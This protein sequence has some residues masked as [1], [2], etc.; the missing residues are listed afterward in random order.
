MDEQNL[1]EH[2]SNEQR[3]ERQWNMF[4]HLSLL[5]GFVI[6]FAGLVVP[7]VLWQLKKDEFPSVT[8]H[9]FVVFNW[10]INAL[11]YAVICFVLTFFLIGVLGFLLLAVLSIVFPIIGG[12][13][14]NDG[15]LWEYPLTFVK[16]F[17]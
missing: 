1:T 11:I 13:K 9:A 3:E 8:A 7:I 17:K 16:V 12:I 4:V 2:P 5:T 15:E 6:P 14:A 10:M